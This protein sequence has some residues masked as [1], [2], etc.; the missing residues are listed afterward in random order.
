TGGGGEL[1]PCTMCPRS[2]CSHSEPLKPLCVR[3]ELAQIFTFDTES[4]KRCRPSPPSRS[5][6]RPRRILY[7]AG[8]RRYLPPQ[9]RDHPRSCLLILCAVVALQIYCEQPVPV[10]GEGEL[11]RTGLS[12]NS[13][14]TTLATVRAADP[15]RGCA[16]LELYT[17]VT[18]QSL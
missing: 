3:P 12:P 5:S 7:P 13:S 6:K 10:G 4:V 11:Q 17:E 16:Y 1:L 9:A 18:S 15:P 8:S 2:A 14:D